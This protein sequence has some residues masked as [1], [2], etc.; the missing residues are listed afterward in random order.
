MGDPSIDILF[1]PASEGIYSNELVAFCSLR[2][3]INE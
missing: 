1:K 3:K 2:K